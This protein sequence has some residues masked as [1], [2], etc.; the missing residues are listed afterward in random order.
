MK[1]KVVLYTEFEG[2][3]TR[4][5][6]F[7]V[8]DPN[9]LPEYEKFLQFLESRKDEIERLSVCPKFFQGLHCPVICNFEEVMTKCRELLTEIRPAYYYYSKHCDTKEL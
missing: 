2:E 1:V 9:A 4:R 7:D 5:D 6:S 8:W 3:G